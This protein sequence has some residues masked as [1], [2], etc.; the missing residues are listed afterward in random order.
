ML[1]KLL[2]SHPYALFC[3]GYAF[4]ELFQFSL[5]VLNICAILSF[6]TGSL[7]HWPCKSTI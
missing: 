4:V 7:A 1:Q 6:S 5:F 2:T 3:H